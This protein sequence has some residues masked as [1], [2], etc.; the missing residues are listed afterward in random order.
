[1]I[2]ATISFGSLEDVVFMLHVK[3]SDLGLIATLASLTALWDR[4]QQKREKCYKGIDGTVGS[5]T[6]NVKNAAKE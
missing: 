4:E 3:R 1:L 5:R 6:K 2:S